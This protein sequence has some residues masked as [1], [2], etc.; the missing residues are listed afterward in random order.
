MWRARF[1]AIAAA[2]AVSFSCGAT[3]AQSWPS[4]APA[5]PQRVRQLMQDRDYAAAVKAI[6]AA[7][8]A[9]DAAKDYLTY[10]KGQALSLEKQ[11]DAAATVFDAMQKD[12]PKSPW[13]R[14]ARLAKAVALARKGDFRAA[15]MI[16][17][18]EAEFLLSADRKQQI[19]DIYLEFADALFKPP[20]SEQKPDYAKAFE[21]YKKALE[22]GPKAE[23]RIEVELRMAECQ[24]NLM[25]Y[26]AA[27]A[28]YEKFVKD[29]PHDRLQIEALFRLGECRLAEGSNKVARRVWQDLLEKYR[30]AQSDRIAD[31]QFQLAR[32]W[33]I[34]KPQDDEE[35]NLGVSALRAFIER[36]PKHKLASQAHLDIAESYVER[37]RYADAATALRRFLADPQYQ[38]RK[39]IPI[40]RNLLGRSLQLQKK[41]TQAIEAWRDYLVKYPSD[42]QWSSVQ[43]EIID[44]EYLMAREKLEAKQYDA[45]N[46]LFAE[47][48]AKYPLDER[49]PG[50]L[51][52]MN[53][54]A[55]EEGKWDEA[56]AGWR[57]IVSKYPD[58]EAASR[59]QFEIAETLEKKLGKL[60]DALEEYRKTTHGHCAAAAHQAIARLTSTS[61]SVATERV[62]RSDETPQLKLIS[63]NVE[64]V[65]VRMYKVD[66]ETYFR[67]MHLARGVEGL[68]VSLI[69]PDKT[70]EFKVPGYVKHRQSQC[71]IDVPLPGGG[72]TGV[73]AVSV[74]S[75]T[76][77][78]T[79]LVIQSD[80]D[81][82]VKSSRD[83]VFVFAEN[84]RTG[85]PW[86]GVRLL[87]SNGRQV[88]AE[89]TTGGDGIVQKS[90]K[91]LKDAA[92]VRVFAVADGN[93]AS[94][95][96]DLHGV[97]VAE[98]LADK[99]YIYTDRPAYRAGQIVHVRGC[100]RRA[101]DDAYT[102]EKGKKFTLDVLD[103]RNRLLSRETVKLGRFGTFH[104]YVVLPTTS[105]QGQYRV[106]VHDDAGQNYSG[107]FR[108]SEYRL[109][110]VRLAIDTPRNV[111]YRG[112]EIEG[113]IRATYYYGAPLAGRE[114]RYQLADDREYTAATD[115]KGEVHFKLPTREFSET[116]VLGLRVA[117]PERNVLT[118]VNYM[119]A[120][121]AFSIHISAVRPV[122]V[123]GETFEATVDTKDAEGK[124]LAQ[125]LT[126]KVLERTTVNGTVGERLVEEHPIET[127]ADGTARKTLK[128][129]RGG[130]YVVRVE[131]T[132]RFKNAI[133]GQYAVQISDDKD[134]V[135]LRILADAHTYKVGD[136]AAIKVHWRERPA[137]GLVTFQG[138]RVLGYQ[139]VELKPGVNRLSIPMTERLA[140][141]FDLS[142][143]VMTNEE[144]GS[145]Q[146]A[147]GSEGTTS[148]K[149]RPAT[150]VAG[151]AG[152]ADERPAV[153]FHEAA[154]PFTVERDLR[155][156]IAAKRRVPH[157]E[158]LHRIGR[159]S[160]KDAAAVE[161]QLQ[162]E[163]AAPIRP[164]DEIE[165]TLTTTDPQGKPVAAQVS[166]AMVEQSLLDRFGGSLSAIDEFFRG[167]RRESA[168]RTTSSVTFAYAPAT[169]P[170]N[171]RLLAEEDRVAAAEAEAAALAA[172]ACVPPSAPAAMGRET[173]S[174]MMGVTPRIIIQ[175]EEEEKL[176]T[177]ADDPFGGSN[178]NVHVQNGTII[179]GRRFSAAGLGGRGR[180]KNNTMLAETQA[181][182]D[183]RIEQPDFDSLIGL[184]ASGQ[185]PEQWQ[186]GFQGQM[187]PGSRAAMAAARNAQLWAALQAL[188]AET[189]YWNP[190]IVTGKDGKATVTFAVPERSTAWR[191]LAKGITTDTLAGQSDES[192][193]VKK[194]LFG[195]LKLPQSFTDG[196][197]AEVIASIHNDAVEKGPIEVTLRTT[198]GERTVAEAKTITVDAKGIREVTF[199]MDLKGERG[200]GR[201]EREETKGER[202]SVAFSLTVSAAGQKKDVSQRTVP[203]LPYGVPVYAAASGVATTDTTTWVEPPRNMTIER[204]TLSILIGPTVDQ[205]L[206]DVLF[207]SPLPCQYESE[208]I[209]SGVETATSDLMAG[210]GLQKLLGITRDAAGPRAER[211]DA[212]I[213][214]AATLLVSSQNVAGGWGWTGT[215][216]G[217]DRYATSRA[218]WG[219]SLARRAG[220]HVPDG[221]FQTAL[222]LVLNQMAAV[223]DN[224][225][226][227][228]AI[229]LHALA[230]AGRGDFALANR[231]HR[232]RLHL[233]TGALA[234]LAMTLAEMDRK[235]MAG[236]LLDVLAHRDLDMD[237]VHH[238]S[239]PCT[240]PWSQSPTE[241]HAL[242]ALALQQTAPGSAKAKE[243]IDW[244]LAHRVGHRWSPDKAT[245]PA[246]LALCRWA[247]ETR[248]DGDRYTLKVFVNDVLAATLDVDPKAGTQTIDVHEGLLAKVGRQRI[249]FQIA[250]RGRYSY[251]CVLG[252]FVPTGRLKAT[253]QDWTVTRTYEPAPLE[254]DGRE[255][256]RGFDVVSG[257]YREFRN[258]LTQLPVG[259][260]GLV[261]LK[262]WRR[263]A[264]VNTPDE[265]LEYLVVTEPIPS[266]ATVIEKSI[267]GGFERF[268]LSPGAITFY[269]GNRRYVE[270][271][272][273]EI[274]G[275]LPGNYRTVPTVVRNAHRPEQLALSAPK[276]LAVLPLGA[277]S[278]DP[279]RLTPR[280]LFELGMSRFSKGNLKAAGEHLTEL[281]K[282]WNLDPNS[283]AYK[284]AVHTLLDV[285]LRLGPPSDVVRY[286]EIVK[287]KWPD[288][289]IPFDKVVKIGAAYHEMGEY[290]RSYLVFRATVESN[291][292]REST[293]AGF[294]ESQGQ[295]VRSVDVLSRLLREYPPEGYVA[296]AAYSLAQHIC[297]KASEVAAARPQPPAASQPQTTSGGMF[298]VD[299]STPE[300][301]N[302]VELLRRAWA[303]FES[304]LTAY[305]DDPAADQA[306][307]ADAGVLLDLKAYKD[308][309]AACDSYAK[310]YPKSDLLDAYWYVIGYCHFAAG[311]D[312]QAIEMCR[313]VADTK[314][315][316]PATG[317]EEDCRN[318]WQ[319]VYILGQVYHSLG[320]AVDAI[321][322]YRRVEDRFA[323]ARQAI[324][325][326]LRKSIELP[327]VSTFK[328]GERA[329]VELKFRNV[330]ACD[331]KVYRIDLMKFGLLKRNLAGI[332][333]I[334]LAGIRPLH[335]TTVSLGDG[336]DYRDRTRKLPL[337]L[338]REGAYLIVCRG[339]D[340]H[341]SGLALVTPLAVEVQADAVSGRVRT[342]VKDRVADK[343]L[344]D[345]DVKVIGSSNEDFVSGQTDLRGVFVAD[346][347]RGGTT[348]IAQAGP[349][350]YAFYRAK[351][352]LIPE[353]IARAAREVQPPQAARR[354]GTHARPDAVSLSDTPAAEK[355]KEALKSPAEFDF[356]E[357]PLKDV[358]DEL[359]NKYNIEIQIDRKAL[360]DVGIGADTPITATLKGISLRAALRLVLR[361][362]ALTYIIQDEVLLITTPEEAEN[363]LETKVYPVA[364]LVLPEGASGEDQAD[365]D[366]LIDL[367]T[368]T[369][370][371]TCWDS[372]GG[373]GSI[374][375]FATN[376]S[377][378][379]SQTQEMHEEIENTLAK[380]RRIGRQQ[381][382]RGLALPPRAHPRP[383]NGNMG[384]M[385]GG[386]GGITPS[387]PAALGGGMFGG[388]PA[389]APN[390]RGAAPASAPPAKDADLLQGVR[391][392]N[393]SNQSK[394]SGKL[395]EMYNNRKGGVGAGGMF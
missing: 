378:T 199:P 314:R 65:T 60:D 89:A 173:Q 4:D 344:R 100:L 52:L 353:M 299:P 77:E 203:L 368:S 225:Y 39:Q 352:T 245:G 70:F 288:E 311:D 161:K 90:Y 215:S 278:T 79:T 248:F 150:V 266:G 243:A 58:S 80:L 328:P 260:R 11:Y 92:D 103:N 63:R 329:E 244:L 25:N 303:M 72:R 16:V 324:E 106:S 82:I 122:Y 51:L 28:L 263:N 18:A 262:I 138:A 305:P 29:H 277:K 310:R 33:N 44:T 56:I 325:Y 224:D 235:P 212:R 137:L 10:L 181:F 165:V 83:E 363:H 46:R 174:L 152:N 182:H 268:E 2:V 114:I 140:P 204:P 294:L 187:P 228:K 121:Q 139:L 382:G 395:K 55:V 394:Q 336:R 284:Q 384:G 37:G 320:K 351:E 3:A 109:E 313:K 249:N 68:D 176:D 233:S 274:Y 6:D 373:P 391:G 259:Q 220:Y 301:L 357:T 375:P 94:N 239:E 160:P 350:R 308:A 229:L 147:A 371:P 247:A 302:R 343:Y 349:G 283:D 360:S 134:R 130:E 168:V 292:Q 221:Q 136:R 43:R 178:R 285:H 188:M 197:E 257:E 232:E 86:P 240:L 116:Q 155:V 195:D 15:E 201:G 312:R 290:E 166:L 291:F 13:F 126:L 271:I 370:K 17:L 255:I 367:I 230:V 59:A 309:A 289:E 123:A 256:P 377:I 50:I 40:A 115:A 84:M 14:R 376:L 209:A 331:L 111:Y 281:L 356:K 142:V 127:A 326:F 385:M 206:F 380:L 365:F 296:E 191:L 42:P 179:G 335:Q 75:K 200:E 110:P 186:I 319:A 234:Y 67:K 66:L 354:T 253:T 49:V 154:S 172:K 24:Q 307:L 93:V 74:S 267:R 346:G 119:L 366:S 81:V 238:L 388:P 64:A 265:Q 54:K 120:V 167:V 104:A 210:L 217:M 131:G 205:S 251:Q 88:F 334:N 355:I 157:A 202:K 132:D 298:N 190:S 236:E 223:H 30:D 242:W 1:L 69:D 76:L 23:K 141:N 272:Q 97:G 198:I 207:G 293:V 231:L 194:A 337:P 275:Y 41:Y 383:E 148:G 20:K 125:K 246:T 85:K 71:A 45:A 164:G 57:R 317:R 250:G 252:G 381:G 151:A 219:L 73:M 222:G 38:G 358:V 318:K 145:R 175:D 287:E 146:S 31:A 170:I 393:E 48:L 322:E 374:M 315:I 347:I 26:P 7:V 386:M 330:A 5:V 364:D 211:L 359:K 276:P 102:V 345:I 332:A 339:D 273:Y 327:E 189:A 387:R 321:H 295:F 118:I 316:D 270:P 338:D 21:F 96:V 34:P 340:L 183:R 177:A 124:P 348:V 162:T 185:R 300:K 61:M 112:E 192:L 279:Y 184:I 379:V 361:A 171:P 390:R 297:A 133:S 258:P 208:Q 214:S 101:I 282:N 62:F 95:A 98:G 108:V 163:E 135:R 129:G 323:D 226:E 196:D 158:I 8:V 237:L 159:R 169:Q 369:V 306:A 12:F 22:S 32:T 9:P 392:A 218:L 241:L 117:L 193:V 227:S 180:I 156:K 264:A 36:F 78:A 113:V 19:A 128:I 87:V 35:L 286:F 149:Q 144:V 362:S 153:R 261:E 280:E 389:N 304:F 341:A 47:F 216:D 53:R 269:V 143:A 254:V 107:T 213:R 99:G 342:T 91:E 333:E 105:P 372:V 27:I